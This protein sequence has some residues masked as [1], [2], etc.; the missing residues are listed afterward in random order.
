MIK[1]VDTPQSECRMNPYNQGRFEMF[2]KPTNAVELITN[3]SLA[4]LDGAMANDMFYSQANLGQF[5]GADSVEEFLIGDS[6]KTYLF[7][8]FDSFKTDSNDSRSTSQVRVQLT[9]GIR[10]GQEKVWGAV[11]FE[12]DFRVISYDD[13][14][15]IFGRIWHLDKPSGWVLTAVPRRSPQT[16]AFGYREVSCQISCKGFVTT[17][18]AKL[19]GDGTVESLNFVTGTAE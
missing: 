1:S 13:I 3:I 9:K 19:D 11:L 2:A 17:V 8:G 12:E 14:S 18:T 5:S 7:D 16:H 10:D 4:I 15:S 6:H